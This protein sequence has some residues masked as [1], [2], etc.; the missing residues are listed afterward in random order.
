MIVD[1]VHLGGGPRHFDDHVSWLGHESLQQPIRQSVIIVN[2]PR[3]N[4][5]YATHIAIAVALA[6]VFDLGACTTDMD[7]ALSSEE[8]TALTAP[9]LQRYL[10]EGL[11]TAERVSEAFLS[12]IETLDKTGPAVNAIIEVNP[13]ALDIARDLDRAFAEHGPT[14]PL[15]GMPVVLKANIDTADLLATSAGSLALAEH[16]AAADAP[17]VARLRAAGAVILAKTNLSE[18]ANF[19]SADSISGWSSLGGQTHNPYVLDRNPCGSSSGSAVAIAARLAPLAVGTETDGSIIC[20]AALN[21]VVGIKP[22]LGLVSQQG[23][24]PIAASQDTAGPMAR[25]VA[26]A[27]SLL[28]VLMDEAVDYTTDASDLTGRRLGV[29]RDYYGA[30]KRARVES[31]QQRWLEMLSNAGAELIDP[32]E[33]GTDEALGAAEFEVLLYEFKAG[34]N[35]YLKSSN[36]LH[37]S[38][39]EL[40][41]YNDAHAETVMP[42]FGQDVFIDAQAKGG[43]DDPPYQAALAASGA[44]MR[45]RLEELFATHRLDALIAPANAPAWKTDRVHGD[46]FLLGSAMIAAISGY[47]SITVPGGLILELPVAISFIGKPGE[48]Q[49]LIDIATVFEQTRGEFPEPTFIRTLEPREKQ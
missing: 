15:H 18:W 16:R 43:L 22:T 31:E 36:A 24:I 29:I 8:I 45:S 30:G 11:L 19:R 20:P 33:V 32:I 47:P 7:Q 14:G 42:H 40:I 17:L 46:R 9:A 6:L 39:A 49:Q 1:R 27:A 2:E 21:G 10:A 26:G 3:T 13:E 4:Q 34:L 41:A 37:T 23:I 44:L 38:L 28:G 48:E 5:A 35:E 12:R 25:T